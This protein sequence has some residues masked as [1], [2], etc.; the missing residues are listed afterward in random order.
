[1]SGQD[2]RPQSIAPETSLTQQK[3]TG[4]AASPFNAVKLELALILV[5]AICLILVLPAT[6]QG[7]L[8]LAGYAFVAAIWLAWRTRSVL[9][10]H[11]Q[12]DGH[13]A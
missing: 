5:L 3:G 2:E 9:R 12:E 11:D 6:L 13:G 8:W 4:V 1:M 7:V 10:R